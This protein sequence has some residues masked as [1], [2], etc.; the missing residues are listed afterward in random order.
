M[1]SSSHP[2]AA[3]DAAWL[4]MDRPTNRMIIVSVLMLEAPLDMRRLRRIVERRLVA[5][6]PRFRQRVVGGG[7]LGG[8]HWQDDDDFDLSLHVHRIALPAPGDERALEELVGDLMA[9]DLDHDRPLWE[10][11]LVESCGAGCALVIRLHHCVADGIALARVLLDLTDGHRAGAAA[12]AVAPPQPPEHSAVDALLAPAH[13]VAGA[14]L[15]AARRLRHPDALLDLGHEVADDAIALARLLGGAQ[16]PPS[17]MKG[18]H[19]AG[20]RVA[21]TPPLALDDVKAIAHATDTTVN[22]VLL[23]AL[24]G[25]LAREIGS[26]PDGPDSVHAIVPFDV[27]PA[28]APLP[29]E[30]GNRFGLVFARLPLDCEAPLQRLAAIHTEMS[31]IKRSRQPAVSYAALQVMGLAPAGVEARLI[32]LLSAK[33]SA[34]VTDVPGPHRTVRLGG[35]A[36]SDAFV[37]APCAGSVGISV[38]IFSY[39]GRVRVGFLSHAGLR[40][41]PQRLAQRIVGQLAELRSAAAAAV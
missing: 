15:A 38:S 33:G 12:G 23:T 39:R 4:H 30:L 31:A 20:Q 24:A 18:H 37:W 6:Y 40:P 10:I 14:P 28:D 41:P 8:P 27:R 36:V 1:M 29:A 35:V 32:D 3:A 9:S 19:G 13:A 17:A 2:M 22:D 34:V 5:R 16:D 11:H 25:A 21:W 7:P 26:E